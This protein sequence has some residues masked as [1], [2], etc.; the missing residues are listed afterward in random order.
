M[1]PFS[2]EKH[3][4]R[5][6]NHSFDRTNLDPHTLDA[7]DRRDSVIEEPL[8]SDHLRQTLPN[9]KEGDE[10][11]NDDDPIGM[12]RNEIVRGIRN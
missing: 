2:C 4:V 8:E 9:R 1:D 7:K 12:A 5:H 6:L 11:D 3:S 10:T